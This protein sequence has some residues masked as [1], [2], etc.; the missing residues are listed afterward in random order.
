MRSKIIAIDFDGTI[1]EHKFPEVGPLV[2]GAIATLRRIQDAGHRTILW[3]CRTGGNLRDAVSLLERH[4]IRLHG[5]NANQW[6]DEYGTGGIK[7][8]AHMY[9]DDMAFGAPLVYGSATEERG[10]I[11]WDMVQYELE[12][13]GWLK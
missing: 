12:E 1:V 2:P 6:D 3:T 13:R 4:N 11:N 7:A 5:V 10:Y 9:I 8:W